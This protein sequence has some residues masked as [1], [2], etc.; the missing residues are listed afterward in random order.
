[1]NCERYQA[2]IEGTSSE[3][4]EQICFLILELCQKDQ[5][6]ATDGNGYKGLEKLFGLAQPI[7]ASVHHTCSGKLEQSAHTSTL[8]M[9]NGNA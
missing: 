7:F 4:F 2:R 6:L 1:M 5:T 8:F 9:V 3:I